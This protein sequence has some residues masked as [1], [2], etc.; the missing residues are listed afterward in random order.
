MQFVFNSYVF[1]LILASA[2]TLSLAVF[3]W[4]RHDSTEARAFFYALLSITIISL[5]AVFSVLSTSPEAADFWLSKMRFIGVVCAPIAFLVFILAY[6]HRLYLLSARRRWLLLALPCIT[7]I[8]VFTND[9]HGLFIERISY[10][11]YGDFIFRNA[12]K[13]GKWFWVH[14]LYCYALLTYIAYFLFRKIQN[15]QY[16]W[17]GQAILMFIGSLFPV[18][19]NLISLLQ[20]I[21]GPALDLTSFGLTATSLT[22]FWA[23]YHYRLLHILPIAGERI[24]EDM[25]DA[26]IVL[27]SQDRIIH[28]NPAL[29]S[30]LKEESMTGLVGRLMHEALPDWLQGMNRLACGNPANLFLVDGERGKHF[31]VNSAPLFWKHQ[32]N[33]IGRIVV[34]HDITTLTQTMQDK[35]KLI[36]ALK[37]TQTELEIL[38]TTDPLTGL[39]NRRYF[40]QSAQQEFNRSLRYQRPLS[41]LMADIDHFKRIN[42]IFGHAVGDRVLAMVAEVMKRD[43]RHVDILA[44]FGGEEFIILLPETE[45]T[46]ALCLAERIR[47]EVANSE[48]MHQAQRITTTVSI[49]LASLE[50]RADSLEA[51]TKMADDALYQAKANGRDRICVYEAQP[52]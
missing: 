2:V 23:L 15:T 31:Q 30:L 42:D 27:D 6:D 17:R 43:V 36:D 16:P 24:L 19:T 44:R 18:L 40:F 46:A 51:L 10:Q 29:L 26:V 48:V 33:T 12:W 5:S 28:L 39:Y 32:K 25:R 37:K 9:M 1:L 7:L 49:G 50:S 14:T 13:P 35:E 47:L 38:A 45:E 22:F 8:V 34:L 21:P 41:M 11:Q 52:H 3:S 20:I 4:F